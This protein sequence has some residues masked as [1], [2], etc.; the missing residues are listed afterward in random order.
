MN[1]SYKNNINKDPNNNNKNNFE[2]FVV[3]FRDT[4]EDVMNIVKIIIEQN[5]IDPF[6][7]F[8]KN[9]NIDNNNKMKEFI[10]SKYYDF[11]ESMDNIKECK[12]LVG[13]TNENIEALEKGIQKFLDEFK[14]DF[15]ERI[16]KKEQLKHI[17][18]EKQKLNSAYIFFAYMNKADIALKS[19][20]YELSIRTMDYAYEKFLKKFPLNSII[21]KRGNELIINGKGKITSIIQEKLTKWLIDV[22]KEQ[23]SI[24]ESLFKKIRDEVE[25]DEKG[26][27]GKDEGPSIGKKSNRNTK[28]IVDSLLLIRNTSNLNY[29]MNKNSVLKYSILG[30]GGNYNEEVEYDIINMV[31]NVDLKFLGQAYNIYKAADNE[32]KYLDYFRNFRQGSIPDLVKVKKNDEVINKITLYEKYFSDIIG[33][34]VI[35]ISVYELYPMFYTKLRFENLMNYLIKELQTNLSFE[36]E[37]FRTTTEYITLQRNIFIFLNAL[38]RIGISEKIG[39]DIRSIMIEMIKEKVMSLNMALISKYNTLFSRMILDDLSSQCL[40]AQN[41]DEFMKYVTQYSI[42]LEETKARAN[43]L[44]YPF[45]L[46]YTKYVIDFNENFKHYVDEIYEFVKPLYDDYESIIP[47]MIK[48]FLKKLNEVFIF[49][50][51]TQDQDINIIS[52]AQICNNIKYVFRSHTFYVDYVRKKCN[53]KTQVAFYTEKSLKEAWQS[54]EEMIYEQ[55]KAKISKFLSDLYGENWLPESERGS[56]NDYVDDM[57]SYLN[58]IYISLSE[59]SGHYIETCFKDAIKFT[60]KSYI[61]II[62][63]HNNV[64]NYNFYGIANLKADLDALDQYFNNIGTKYKGFDQCLFPIKNMIEKIFYEKKIEDF[65]IENQK[66]DNFYKIDE[67]KLISFLERYKNIKS[68]KEMKGKVTESDIQS[69]IKKLKTILGIK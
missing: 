59:L 43:N 3:E 32:N 13:K 34:I 19:Q 69:M 18:K 1:S 65:H 4:R 11:V 30:G 5:K 8:I 9:K 66:I 23:K 14:L 62:F 56:P 60:T 17:T 53:I 6:I 33:F 57:T 67:N 54:Y 2:S 7:K 27:F 22:N 12:N 44:R 35:Q 29:M 38:E 46:P 21:Y 36:F 20:Q 42:I 47:E 28:S 41:P 64:K 45:K 63:N 31:S 24:G 40:V 39:I 16:K 10:K 68:K 58:V 61:D 37:T 50:S 52:L 15:I 55:I 26:G 48:S 49:F 51:N 25:S